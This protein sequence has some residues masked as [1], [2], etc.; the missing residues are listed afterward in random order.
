MSWVEIDISKF[1]YCDKNII[2]KLYEEPNLV[3]G[4]NLD[5]LLKLEP[6]KEYKEYQKEK[7]R[8]KKSM[9]SLHNNM[10]TSYKE[11]NNE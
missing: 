7:E 5:D 1:T 10:N 4:G 11:D 2:E 8:I 3:S 6:T 9:V